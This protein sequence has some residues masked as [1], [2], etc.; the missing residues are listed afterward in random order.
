MNIA[1]QPPPLDLLGLDDLLDE[2]L[3]CPFA[4]HQ[5]PVQPSLMQRAC[6]QPADHQQKFD[7]PCGELAPLDGVD[8]QH[9]HQAARVGLH[10]HRHHR[11]EVAA[12]QR[13]EGHVAGIALLVLG[14]DDGLAVAGDPSGNALSQREADLADLG[15]ERRRGPAS[16]SDR[17]LSSRT[18]T[19][20]TSLAVAAVII[21]AAAAASGSTP[22]P[23][24]AAWI[25]SRS[26]ASS[27]SASTR[28]WTALGGRGCHVIGRCPPAAPWP[29]RLFGR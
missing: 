26:R 23:D 3:V 25:N 1:R 15:V 2:V 14:D 22:G 4:G 19:K 21:R 10:R 17:S 29:P 6:D 18:C 24:D 7:V 12:A 20:Q 8:V 13:L 16:V 9:A 5:L 27:R 28:S 11:R